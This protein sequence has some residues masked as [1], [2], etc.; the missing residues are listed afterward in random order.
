VPV[1]IAGYDIENALING[2]I[3]FEEMEYEIR[4]EQ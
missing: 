1:P 4:I 3:I 2:I